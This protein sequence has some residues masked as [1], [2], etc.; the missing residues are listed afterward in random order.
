MSWFGAQRHSASATISTFTAPMNGRET[1]SESANGGRP[2]AAASV[3][4]FA[5]WRYFRD[6]SWVEDFRSPS[7]LAGSFASEYSVTPFG[8]RYIAVYT[9]LGLSPRIMGRMADHPWGPWSEPAVLF[10]CPDMGRDKKLFCYAAKAHPALSSGHDLVVSNVVNSFDF[11]QV[12]RDAKLYWP[13][14]VRV[15]LANSE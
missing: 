1:L 3:G 12:T 10:E 8:K 6:E 4:N 9:E 14:L 7:P 11:G 13:K 5:A 15:T 2:G